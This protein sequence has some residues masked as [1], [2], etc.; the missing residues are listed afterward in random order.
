MFHNF[1]QTISIMILYSIYSSNYL[2]S[3]SIIT[4]LFL[5]LNL[6]III[7]FTDYFLML[8]SILIIFM[9]IRLIFFI[10]FNYF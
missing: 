7:L 8:L 10:S 9:T 4:I 2:V 1:N 5:F 3:F 6:K